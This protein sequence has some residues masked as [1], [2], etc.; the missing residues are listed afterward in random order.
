MK[1]PARV[2]WQRFV[3]L[4]FMQAL[5]ALCGWLLLRLLFLTCRT[6][7]Q[8]HPASISYVEGNAPA[9]FCFWHGRMLMQPFFKPPGRMMNVLISRHRDGGIIAR[10]ISRFGI[11]SVRGSSSTASHGA[12]KALI[13]R[14]EAKE[15]VCIT[16]DGPRG[17]ARI[18]A[19]GAVRLARAAPHPIIPVSF[20]AS[21]AWQLRS[22]DRFLVPKPFSVL[23][24][25]ADAP[26]EP[27]AI[28]NVDITTACLTLQERLNLTTD[29]ADRI[30]G[31]RKAAA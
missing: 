7:H 13:D 15:N 14:L 31:L 20:S 21:R 11:R 8:Y 12:V 4:S 19:S 1:R 17:P 28:E 27:A 24:I 29:E 25:I 9:I 2:Y 23:Y 30:A 22:W 26:L 18:A 3:R 5:L 10:L 6:S 16:P